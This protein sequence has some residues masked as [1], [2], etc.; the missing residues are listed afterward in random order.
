MNKNAHAERA[1]LKKQCRLT[2]YMNG[3]T[4]QAN[5]HRNSEPACHLWT[6]PDH[7]S[8]DIENPLFSEVM[9]CLKG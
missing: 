6:N 7:H 4:H 2:W 8:I 5:I 9:H 3:W 1:K